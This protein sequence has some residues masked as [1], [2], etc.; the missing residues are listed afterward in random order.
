ML[1]CL[2][3]FFM[4]IFSISGE[5]ESNEVMIMIMG[6]DLCGLPVFS[7]REGSYLGRIADF[8]FDGVT[9]ALVGISLGKIFP[10][11]RQRFV[12]REHICRIY[13]DGVVISARE[14]IEKRQ[15]LGDCCVSY[16]EFS[17]DSSLFLRE[18][19]VVSDFILNEWYEIDGYE[20]SRGLWHDLVYGRSFRPRYNRIR[21]ISK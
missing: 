6:R 19:E 21:Q 13:K 20:I 7:W 4:D 12:A 10:G 2:P 11:K 8:F 17:K 9:M 1:K 5:N 3:V 18:G 16:L 14:K 15:Y